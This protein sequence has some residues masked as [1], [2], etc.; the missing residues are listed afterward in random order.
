[1]KTKY[2]DLSHIIEDGTITYKNLLAPIICDVR[3]VKNLK[4]FMKKGQVF[5]LEK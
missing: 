1:M 4:S 5:K 2:I 3:V